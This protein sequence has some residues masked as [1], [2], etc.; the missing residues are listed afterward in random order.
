M[1]D[2]GACQ[3]TGNRS[4]LTRS[5]VVVIAAMAFVVMMTGCGGIKND[6]VEKKLFRLSMPGT[7]TQSASRQ[8]GVPLLIKRLEISPEFSGD[9]FV[10]RIGQDQY[11][12]D[13]YN[14]YMTTPERMITDYLS[15]FLMV[16][17]TFA[18][19]PRFHIPDQTWQM[20]G[21]ILNLYCDRQDPDRLSMVVAIRLNLGRQADNGFDQILSKTYAQSIPMAEFNS[22]AYIQGID[23]ALKIILNDFLSDIESIDLNQLDNNAS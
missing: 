2:A 6:Y 5:V 22:Q 10:Y 12:Q 18:P 11:A 21:K 23:Q 19:V 1:N 7:M 3:L 20:W 8:E 13:Y 16:S 9:E 4:A 17:D 14:Q 15:E